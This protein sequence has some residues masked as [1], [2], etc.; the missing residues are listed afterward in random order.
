MSAGTPSFV[1]AGA[2]SPDTDRRWTPEELLREHDDGQYELVDGRLVERHLGFESSYIA[3]ILLT[4]LR[5]HVA[6]EGCGWVVGSEAG[7]QCFADDPNKVRK[8][9]GAYVSFDRLPASDPPKGF[10]RVA[11]DLAF[12][13]VSPHDLFSEVEV[14]VNDFL[15]AGV[16]LV[17]VVD[18]ESRTVRVHR[19]EHVAYLK[20]SDELTGGDVLPRF[21]CQVAELFQSPQAVSG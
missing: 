16:R 2:R 14:K 3:T 10:C 12:E 7:Y 9:D 6:E 5:Q 1:S 13:V 20:E 18:P 15:R 21:K 4:L 11:P 17:W 19:S 8:P